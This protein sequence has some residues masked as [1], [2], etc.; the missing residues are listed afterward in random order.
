MSTQLTAEDAKQSLSAHVEAKGTEIHQR[1]GPQLG[2]DQLQLL[3]QDRAC[4]RYPCDLV[5]DAS[6]LMAGEFAFPLPKGA[7][8][9]DGFTMHIHPVFQSR[10]DDIPF[11]VLYQLVVVNYGE[12]ASS[13]DAERFGAAA[14][15]LNQ[16]SYYQALCRLADRVPQG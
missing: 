14:L 15:G 4:V 2:W 3:L 10:L 7:R 8:P 12:F 16:E 13:D 11:L 6:H 9:E 5:F 1:Y